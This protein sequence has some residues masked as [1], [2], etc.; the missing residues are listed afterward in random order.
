MVEELTDQRVH[1][2]FGH[3]RWSQPDFI[4]HVNINDEFRAVGGF[5][6]RP[7][8]TVHGE[9]RGQGAEFTACQQ[10]GVHQS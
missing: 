7:R 1:I 6:A 2:F 4:V 5:R 10:T 8:G 3:G 9:Y